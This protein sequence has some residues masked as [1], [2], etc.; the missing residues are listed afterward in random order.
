MATNKK[1]F[2]RYYNPQKTLKRGP[3][4]LVLAKTS[5]VLYPNLSE[6]LIGMQNVL[7][8]LMFSYGKKQQFCLPMFH[9]FHRY[10]NM[11]PKQR[12]HFFKIEFEHKK[13]LATEALKFVPPESLSLIHI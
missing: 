4:E 5:Q 8:C 9:I 7:D 6:F 10:Y 3:D 11:T 13:K 1:N 2:H 12:S